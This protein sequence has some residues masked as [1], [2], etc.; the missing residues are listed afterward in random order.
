[1]MKTTLKVEHLGIAVDDL[2]AYIDIFTKMG[3]KV[4]FRGKAPDFE[5]ECVFID[6]GNI[7][8][9]LIRGTVPGNHINRFI[10]RY[11]CGFHHIAVSG[12]DIV[13][14]HTRPGAK[15]GME[16]SFSNPNK[17][18]RVLIENVRYRKN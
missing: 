14:G 1:M 12:D 15:P 13:M 8:I 16:V 5:A 17:K 4:T 11:G 9:E 7:E 18:N 2:D 10:E 6:M 3:G